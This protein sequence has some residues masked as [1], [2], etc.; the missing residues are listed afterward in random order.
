MRV[1]REVDGFPSLSLL[2][3]SPLPVGGSKVAPTGGRG[4]LLLRDWPAFLAEMTL[5]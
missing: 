3:G 2:D 5:L 4:L 1:V